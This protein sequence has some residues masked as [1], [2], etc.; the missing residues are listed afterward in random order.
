MT[1]R[2]VLM[3]A[4]L[5]L[6]IWDCYAVNG[7]IWHKQQQEFVQLFSIPQFAALQKE[8]LA[9]R[10]TVIEKL[11]MSG[12]VVKAVYYEEMNMVMFKD[13]DTKIDGIFGQLWYLLEDYLNFTFI[14]IK[15]I[16]RNFGELLENGNHSGLLGMLERNEAQV[17]MRS[18]FYFSRMNAVDYI[19]PAWKSTYYIYVHPK[20]LYDNT[21]V[22]TLFSWQTWL[23]IIFLF[24]I[25]S[26]VGYFLQKVSMSKSKHKRK[27][28]VGF[29]LGDHFF[30]SFTIMS[31][32]GYIPNA[33][34]NKFKILTLSKTLFA[35]LTLLAFS[36]HLIYRMT[37]REQMLSF[38]DIDSLFNNTK[39]FLLVYRGSSFAS[40][41]LV[42]ENPSARMNFIDIA[43][44]MYSIICSNLTR[45]AIFDGD[46]RF[47][48]LSRKCQLRATSKA[49]TTWIT[50]AFQKNY[51]YKKNFEYALQPVKANINGLG[52]SEKDR[53]FKNRLLGIIFR[54]QTMAIPKLETFI[55]RLVAT[56]F[57]IYFWI[58]KIQLYI[59]PEMIH[60]DEWIISMERIL[61]VSLGLFCSMI[62]TSFGAVLFMF[63]SKSG[64]VPPFDKFE[65]LVYNTKFNVVTLKDS[66]GETL[67]KVHILSIYFIDIYNRAVFGI[68]FIHLSKSIFM[69]PFDSF[70]TLVTNTKYNIGLKDTTAEA[71]FNIYLLKLWITSGIVKNFKYK[72]SIDLG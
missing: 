49:N 18:T 24:I 30:Y 16:D 61:E 43:E 20:W 11:D 7:I 38:E 25:L 46:D 42:G 33:F 67:F 50:I 31:A 34:Y 45:Y 2:F 56:E 37:Y 22:F 53:S 64:F 68:L 5:Q 66:I 54:N 72:R 23:Y 8:N 14:P 26:C 62:C 19:T 51:R 1:T 6:A 39:Y 12:E 40:S 4:T 63:L 55:S 13:N 65:S 10:Q 41:N 29:S 57:S 69:P 21:W 32:R 15:S 36:S 59:H 3:V 44:D 35:W 60:D 28:S 58:N 9:K 47:M 17:I 70:T 27:D 52:M 71:I 48:A